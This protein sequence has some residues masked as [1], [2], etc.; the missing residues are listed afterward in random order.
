MEK[1][2]RELTRVTWMNVGWH[3]IAANSYSK[4]QT[5]PMI[6]LADSDKPHIQ[7]SPFVLLLS[8][9]P[10]T[11]FTAVRVCS[12]F[13]KLCI[14]MIFVI[15]VRGFA[16]RTSH[17]AVRRANQGPLPPV[18]L[19]SMAFIKQFLELRNPRRSQGGWKAFIPSQAWVR[20]VIRGC[21]AHDI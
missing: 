19:C 14:A 15:F 6:T 17:D 18:V 10:D 9:K 20:L 11:H 1:P 13:P 16:L 7:Q 2:L 21:A 8:L 5:W 4:P 12:R 3:H